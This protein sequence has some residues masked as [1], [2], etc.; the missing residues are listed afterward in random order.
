[1]A[2]INHLIFGYR[3]ITVNMED[4]ATISSILLRNNYTS[5]IASDG[6]LYVREK[7]YINIRNILSGRI[8]RMQNFTSS[9]ERV[10]RKTGR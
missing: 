10:E 5:E 6:K 9:A 4:L 8:V 7:D 2:R 1:M 3:I